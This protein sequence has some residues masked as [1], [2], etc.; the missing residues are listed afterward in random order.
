M[1][2][3]LLIS[4]ASST[5]RRNNAEAILKRHEISYDIIDAV[6]GRLG[7]DPLLQRYDE[8]SFIRHRGRK[9]LAGE[10]GCYASHILAWQQVIKLDKPVVVLEDDFILR[11][12]FC[13][14]IETAELWTNKHHFIRLEPWK[15]KLFYSVV[16]QN[17]VKLVKFLKVPQCTT[18]YFITPSCA[19]AFLDASEKMILPVDVFIRNTY[20]HR[21]AIYGLDPAPVKPG[22]DKHSTIGCRKQKMMQPQVRMKKLITRLYSSFLC[23]LVNITSR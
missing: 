16:Q 20:L 19:Q 9:A 14:L 7:L 12:D 18:G 22:G 1:M 5:T 4:L 13:A 6:D 21:Q 3:V 11:D 17:E 10:L 2:K 23:A 8:S 15:T